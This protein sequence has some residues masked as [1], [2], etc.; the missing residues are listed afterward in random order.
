MATDT[1]RGTR[2]GAVRKRSQRQTKLVGQKRWTK[3]SR[4]TGEFMSQKK[5]GAKKYKGV[6][7]ESKRQG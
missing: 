2:K 7:R 3:R 5:P 4:A 6:R 1:G